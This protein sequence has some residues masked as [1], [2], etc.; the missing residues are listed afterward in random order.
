M[1]DVILQWNITMIIILFDL[2]F[3]K[4]NYCSNNNNTN[5]YYI[6]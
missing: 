4:N 1:L 6:V 2:F 3:G 5:S